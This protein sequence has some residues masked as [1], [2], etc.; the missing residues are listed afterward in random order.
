MLEE[1]NEGAAYLLSL[2]KSKAPAMEAA[3]SGAAAAPARAEIAG[4][5]A[6]GPGSANAG[7]AEKRRS[8][9][10]K[11]QGSVRLQPVGGTASIWATCTDISLHGCYVEASTPYG[12]GTELT[13]RIEANNCRVEATGDVRV[14]YP[15][16]GMGIAFLTMREEDRERLLEL[17][18]SLARPKLAASLRLAPEES[19]PAQ[20]DAVH[21]VADASAAL[22]GM[23]QFFEN[24]QMMSREI[25]LSILRKG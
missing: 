18:R 14:S 16:L 10:Y 24:R 2:K 5:A 15:G 4:A 11:C 7:G 12:M 3:Q 9:R 25:F 19:L 21:S 17:V 6:G 8:P 20:L 22:R 23:L 13:M 1:T